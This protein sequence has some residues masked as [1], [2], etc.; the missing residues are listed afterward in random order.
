MSGPTLEFLNK[1]VRWL[2]AERPLWTAVLDKDAIQKV[3]KNEQL[4]TDQAKFTFATEVID[5]QT[6]SQVLC[7]YRSWPL[8]KR[9]E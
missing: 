7:P 8:R 5:S 3:L 9:I 6:S 4:D 2:N 1:P